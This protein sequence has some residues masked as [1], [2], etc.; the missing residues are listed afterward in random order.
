M[1]QIVNDK[2]PFPV[3]KNIN[4]KYVPMPAACDVRGIVLFADF[5]PSVIAKSPKKEENNSVDGYIDI[6][7]F[8]I[9]FQV[10]SIIIRGGGGE[11]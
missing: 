4:C 8:L 1:S 10:I 3:L 9:N 7:P 2:N 11:F 5:I 6:F